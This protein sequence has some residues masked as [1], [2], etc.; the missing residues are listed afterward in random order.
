MKGTGNASRNYSAMPN[1]FLLTVPRPTITVIGVSGSLQ[2]QD[3]EINAA[4]E[5]AARKI[6]MYHGINARYEALHSTGS[7]IFDYASESS[8]SLDYNQELDQ[9]K[10]R[11][12]FDPKSDV[13]TRDGA[14][15][16]RFTYPESY[17]GNINYSSSKALNGRPAWV[18][19]PPRH[20]GGYLAGVGYS[21]RQLRWQD[22]YRK[23]YEASLFQIIT[24]FS[25]EVSSKEVAG[26]NWSSTSTINMQS[27]ATLINFLIIDIWRD[28]AN[29]A[30][31]TLAIARSGG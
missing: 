30:V 4:R 18:N 6:S 28:P 13:V 20:I 5:D 7:S 10:E 15:F 11:L 24:Q 9:Y 17:P 8:F 12:N 29:Q 25:T 2:K 22:T 3:D 14:V 1:N 19:N 16:V 23:S 31:W 26:G 27:T 21:G